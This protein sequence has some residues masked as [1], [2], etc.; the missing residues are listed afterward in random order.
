MARRASFHHLLAHRNGKESQHT[1]CNEEQNKEEDCEFYAETMGFHL[2][3]IL[4][5][6]SSDSTIRKMIG[7]VNR[8]V[9]AAFY[10]DKFSQRMTR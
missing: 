5:S 1:I 7:D 6:F 3:D 8:T 10:L 4:D 2:K 9:L